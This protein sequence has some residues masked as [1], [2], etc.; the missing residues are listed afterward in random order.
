MKMQKEVVSWY[1]TAKSLFS[2]FSVSRG[3]SVPSVPFG[4][5]RYRTVLYIPQMAVPRT[6]G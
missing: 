2:A 4:A 6:A 5:V 3:A 1:R